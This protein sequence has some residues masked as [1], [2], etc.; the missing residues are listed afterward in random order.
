MKPAVHYRR[1]TEPTP[2][3]LLAFIYLWPFLFVWSLNAPSWSGVDRN[4]FNRFNGVMILSL[5]DI[6]AVLTIWP[7]RILMTEAEGVGVYLAVLLVHWIW[8]DGGRGE[9]L[10]K[11]F[12]HAGGRAKFAVG[13]LSAAL[14]GGMLVCF[15]STVP[16]SS[17]AE[18]SA[19]NPTCKQATEMSAAACDPV[20]P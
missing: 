18:A 6:F 12:R 1:E 17:T 3:L 2:G 13:V 16:A 19:T 5:L 9:R 11:E 10:R 14:F 20:K 15:F 8:L 7:R 4:G